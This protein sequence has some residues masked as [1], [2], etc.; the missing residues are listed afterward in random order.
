MGSATTYTRNNLSIAIAVGLA[1]SLF[2]MAAFAFVWLHGLA[3]TTQDQACTAAIVAERQLATQPITPIINGQLG[4][5]D[6]IVKR[7]CTM[8]APDY[9]GDVT[10]EL[11]IGGLGMAVTV[12]LAIYGRRRVPA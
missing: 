6:A 7:D 9:N 1:V 12:V 4:Y 5:E 8:E 3:T 11:W 10:Y 2:L